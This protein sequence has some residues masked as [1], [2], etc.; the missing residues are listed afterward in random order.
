MPDVTSVQKGDDSMLTIVH[1][2]PS[3]MSVMHPV[4]GAIERRMLWLARAQAARGHKVIIYSTG[5]KNDHVYFHGAEI[6][7]L[8]C[9]TPRRPILFLR[10]LELLLR[11]CCEICKCPPH[12]LH[13]HSVP[14]GA[15]LSRRI[16]AIKVLSYDHF[17]FRR[18]RKTPLFTSYRRALHQFDRLLPVSEYVKVRSLEYWGLTGAATTV[19][20]NGVDT[21]TYRPDAAKRAQMRQSLGLADRPVVLWAGRVNYVKGT[22]VLIQAYSRLRERMPSIALVVAGPADRFGNTGGN[23]LTRRVVSAGG[24]YLGAVPEH[25]LPSLFNMCDVFVY[26]SRNE[27]FGMAAVE[28]QAC[29]K[30][31]VC[32]AVGGLPEIVAEG[33]GFHVPPGDPES[34]ANRT[35]QLLTD[36]NLYARMSARALE[37]SARFSWS[38]V[39]DRLDDVYYSA[40]LERIRRR[41]VEEPTSSTMGILRE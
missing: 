32:S 41:R 30:P 31:V 34:V 38:L 29:G 36:A 5:E 4:A 35:H 39:A 25:Q 16:G 9:Y 2:G 8:R 27:P 28:A 14:E 23:D 37:N 18:G 10:D 22:D 21:A 11:A 40:L 6:R 26:P 3:V 1:V 19:A 15:T 24:F 20:Y 12:V 7:A 13:F 33:A 17:N